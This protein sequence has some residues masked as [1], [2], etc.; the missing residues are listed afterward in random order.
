MKKI[1]GNLITLILFSIPS[2]AQ[3]FKHKFSINKNDPFVKEGV[4]FTASFEQT[5]KNI[6][7]MFDFDLQKS[8]DYT[9]KRI[10]V[11]Q[12]EEY[13]DLKVEY[14]YLIYPLRSGDININFKLTKKVTT[15]ESVAYSFSG[16][17]DNIKGL[18][19][20]DTDVYLDPLKIEVKTIPTKTQIVGD[21]KISYKLN[22]TSALAYEPIN[23][24]IFIEGDGF[25][26]DINPYSFNNSEFKTFTQK[27]I[28]KDNKY[29]YSYAFSH[30]NSF[31]IPKVEVKA[32]NPKNN[33]EYILSVKEQQIDISSASHNNLTDKSD[34]PKPFNLDLSQY[35]EIIK[36]I[37]I[38]ILGVITHKVFQNFKSHKQ[39]MKSILKSKINEASTHKELLKILISQNNPKYKESIQQLES[40]I[41]GSQ[42]ISL[43]QIKSGV[44][45]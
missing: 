18:V 29:I 32:F 6:V 26:I 20:K 25:P 43:K 9:F 41:Y 28:F 13:H 37:L 5:N 19:T 42:Q 4:I 39:D 2:M 30:N 21:Y 22:K 44:K 23:L 36:Y 16:D 7:L 10:D 15:D 12:S 45:L 34:S 8:K 1:L 31:T 3:D 14:K 27:P 33:N 17:R 35:I 38:F 40:S 11:K 24:S